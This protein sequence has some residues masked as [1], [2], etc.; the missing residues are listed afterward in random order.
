MLLKRYVLVVFVLWRSVRWFVFVYNVLYIVTCMMLIMYVKKRMRWIQN[1]KWKSDLPHI[2]FD[3]FVIVL[4][5]FRV[6]N[7]ICKLFV[8]FHM[9]IR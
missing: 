8:C 9:G 1:P 7:F 6:S 4:C 5:V 3:Y 2:V